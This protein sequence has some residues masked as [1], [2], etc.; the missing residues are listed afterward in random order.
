MPKV[1]KDALVGLIAA[2]TPYD[3]ET[4]NI[5]TK[6]VFDNIKY[7]LSQGNEVQLNGFG[8]FELKHRAPRTGMNPHTGKP[9]PIPERIVQLSSQVLSLK[10]W[11]CEKLMKARGISNGE[12]YHI[13]I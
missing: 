7:L 6:S 13:G 4:V 1:N 5:I 3:R 12:Y 9:V 10:R 2:D 8:T 11:L